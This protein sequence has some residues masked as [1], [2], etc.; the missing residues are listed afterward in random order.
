MCDKFNVM[1]TTINICVFGDSIAYGAWDGR[2]G[3]VDRLRAHLHSVTLRSHF[4]SYYF[5]YPLGIPGNTAADVLARLSHEAAAREP[6]IIIFAVGIN[7]ARWQEPGRIPHVT[8]AAF[9]KNIAELIA[10][11]RR[12]T[13]RIIFI[14]LT[15]VD[16]SKT[17]PFEPDC[18]FENARIRSFDA[19]LRELTADADVLFLDVSA[20]LSPSADLEDGLHPNSAGH[21]KLF[22]L[23]RDFLTEHAPL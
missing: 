2:G 4:Q 22:A 9:R 13:S 19:I 12:F 8:E 21:E 20:A 11:A 7:D 5:L 23:V 6:H 3:W 16:E 15:P 10:A 17:M 18:A 14:G 1:T